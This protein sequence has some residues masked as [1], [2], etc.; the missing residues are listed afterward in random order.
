MEADKNNTKTDDGVRGTA[1]EHSG[2]GKQAWVKPAISSF[3]P[4]SAAQGISY[5]PSDGISNLT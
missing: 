5:R 1:P 3:K 4:V 2:T